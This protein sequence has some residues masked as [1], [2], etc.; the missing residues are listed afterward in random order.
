MPA[1]SGVVAPL[2]IASLA[3]LAAC[4]R[5]RAPAALATVREC[6]VEDDLGARCHIF[7]RSGGGCVDYDPSRPVVEVQ[8]D[9][10]RPLAHSSFV[11]S[12]L[13]TAFARKG[14]R[15]RTAEVDVVV[16]HATELALTES[17]RTLLDD[18]GKSVHF[19]IDARGRIYQ[20][21][22]TRDTAWHAANRAINR[23][24]IGVEH[25]ACSLAQG[26]EDDGHE[27]GLVAP[28]TPAMVA[29]S[30]SLVRALARRFPIVLDRAHVIG[31]DQVPN[32][33]RIAEDAA[34]CAASVEACEADPSYGGA[35]HHVDPGITWDWCLYMAAI[36]GPCRDAL[37]DCPRRDGA[38]T[39][40]PNRDDPGA[41]AP[42]G[43]AE[44]R[45]VHVDRD[46]RGAARS[47]W[48]AEQRPR[49]TTCR[50]GEVQPPRASPESPAPST[51]TEEIAR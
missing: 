39:C 24:S 37:D 2:V 15:G 32:R 22:S 34:P 14:E 25:V 27:G 20:L 38:W 21:A 29:A 40:A 44:I 45:C 11:S 8:G 18:P 1:R 3:A 30:A 16:V 43:T 41:G 51:R 7:C 33:A 5:A 46:E 36:G 26:C 49:P 31:H 9:D 13:G 35:N 48:I 23:R 12:S 10:G 6:A 4:G 42:S 50:A 19:M 17:G 47:R 28:Y